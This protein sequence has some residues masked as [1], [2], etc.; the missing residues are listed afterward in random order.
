M[1]HYLAICARGLENLLAE[2]LTQLGVESPKLMHAGVKFSADAATAMRCCLW[3][4][5]ASRFIHILGEFAVRDDLDLYLGAT[6]ISWFNYFDSDTK[7][8]VDFNGTNKEIRNS[9]YGALKVKDAIVDR[10]N[11]AGLERPNIDKDSPDLRIH[12]RLFGEKGILGLDMVGS[13]LHQRSYR[14]DAGLA[15]LREN[16]AAALVMRSGWKEPQS[17]L[18]PMCGSGTLLIEAA[19]MAADVAPGLKRHRWGFEAIKG[20]DNEQWLE[21]VSAA[22]VKARK[23]IA[24]CETRFWGFDSDSRVL[25]TA[26]DNAKRAGVESLITFAVGDAARISRP[27]GFDAGVILSNPPYGERLGTTPSLIALY[28]EFGHRL[29]TEFSGCQ[30]SIYSGSDELLSCLRMRAEKQY[31]INNG[32]LACT[33]KNY[34]ITGAGAAE[35]TEAGDANVAPDFANRLKKN[36]TKLDKWAKQQ[37]ID[38]YRIYDADLPNY[39]AA[40]DRYKDYIIIQEY[41]APKSV[42]EDKAR[43]RLMDLMRATMQ[44]TGVDSNHVVMKVREKQKGT[45]QYNK[46]SDAERYM[47]V[48]EYGVNL[49]VNLF[50]YLDTGL[51]LDHR[52]TRKKIGELAASRDFLNLF[53]YTGSATVHAAVGG[54]RTTTTVDMSKTYLSWAE[55]N[56]KL[57]GKVGRQHQYIQAD[58][59]KWLK[60]AKQQYDLIFIDPPTFSNSKRMEGTFDIQRDHQYLMKNLKRLLRENGT[61]VFSNNKRGFKM[62]LEA[63]EELGLHAVNISAKTL[64]QD[65]AR[66]KQIHNCWII[67]HK[68]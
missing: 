5:T 37:G 57:N 61:I 12:M 22:K 30:A 60:E 6:A 63:I 43:R 40:V 26:K 53:A 32:A 41:A 54:A 17:M 45:N 56:M 59:L 4:R 8:V 47:E 55:R 31:K 2:E 29:K 34:Q 58:C 68:K 28:S 35:K 33:L 24:R 62:D 3:S 18:D 36:I 1:N 49:E 39:N 14:T 66:N 27:E 67:T 44:V 46:L 38:C 50:D 9:Q 51:F 52:L 65:F 13:G 19:L 21:I 23:G 11:K 10:F 15:P 42:P 7:I 16:L 20:F 48:S 64:P 25:R